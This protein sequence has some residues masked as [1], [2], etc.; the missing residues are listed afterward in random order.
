MATERNA[1]TTGEECVNPNK[2]E[3]QHT[4]LPG[5]LVTTCAAIALAALAALAALPSASALALVQ[6]AAIAVYPGA[7]PDAATT[8][9]LRSQMGVEGAAYRTNDSLQKVAA[10]YQQQPGMK[11]MGDATKESAA[12]VAG[13]KEEFNAVMK[14]KMT[15]GCTHHVT[16]QNPW[17]D[18]K[19]G[20]MVADTL[21]S[22]VKQ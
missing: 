2:T 8:E 13:C 6:N 17:M 20:K 11:P 18:M 10:F 12:F 7:K 16:V 5:G 22:I 15:T 19:T 4:R 3:P 9:F 1:I 14:K 21:V